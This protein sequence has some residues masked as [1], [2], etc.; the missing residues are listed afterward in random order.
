MS[1]K[2]PL[3]PTGV[4][5]GL[6]NDL[7]TVLD[8][9][10]GTVKLAALIKRILS[11]MFPNTLSKTQS[12]L[13]MEIRVGNAVF[14]HCVRVPLMWKR[15]S[16]HTLDSNFTEIRD[17]YDRVPSSS[18]QSATPTWS[19]QPVLV[20]INRTR[21]HQV[22]GTLYCPRPGPGKSANIPGE[23]LQK[24]LFKRLK[25]QNAD[26]D[27]YV[28]TTMLAI[29]QW[30]CSSSL[31]RSSPRSLPQPSP[32]PQPE[33]RDIPVK[34]IT[35]D[36]EKAEFIIYSTVVTAAF[37]DRFAFPSKA[38]AATDIQGRGLTINLTRVQIWPL[39]GLKERLAKALGPEIAG[40]LAHHDIADSNIE[41]WETDEERA[42]RLRNP[43]RKKSTEDEPVAI[44]LAKGLITSPPPYLDIAAKRRQ[45][46]STARLE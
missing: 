40:D 43:K 28:V 42:I 16:K 3:R 5:R 44:D 15:Y 12:N 31:S 10:T 25:P 6:T 35:Q 46:R 23:R 14:K 30:H 7:T 45:T 20:F 22:R 9:D 29:A 18:V 21:L 32:L 2:Y 11:T 33:V 37:L 26:E 38:P 36:H 13:R 39:L 17:S 27:S 34:I 8:S 24:L 4:A 1:S 19:Y 41:T